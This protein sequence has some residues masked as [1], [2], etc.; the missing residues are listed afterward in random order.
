MLINSKVTK[1][2]LFGLTIHENGIDK[3]DVSFIQVP[4]ALCVTEDCFCQLSKV[5]KA[6]NKRQDANFAFLGNLHLFHLSNL[7]RLQREGGLN[8]IT[9]SNQC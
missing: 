6:D 5:L 3:F 7:S 2:P 9:F 1:Q 8:T 4:P